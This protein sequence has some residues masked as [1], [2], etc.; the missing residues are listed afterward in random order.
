MHDVS[1]AL[2]CR[3]EE[4]FRLGERLGVDVDA[5]YLNGVRKSEKGRERARTWLN[6]V[7][8]RERGGKRMKNREKTVKMEGGNT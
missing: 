3:H 8:M 2:E 7:R 5:L 1:F 6:E 4:A